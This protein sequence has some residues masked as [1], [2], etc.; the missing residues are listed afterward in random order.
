MEYFPL[1]RSF[2]A[3]NTVQVA[4]DLLGKTLIRIL[5]NRTVLKGM[6]VETEAYQ[7]DDAASHAFRGITPRTQPLFGPVGHA[8]I[9]FIYGNYFCLNIVA[10]DSSIRAGGVLIR[11]LEPIEGMKAML[12]FRH[13]QTIEN[14]TNGP[15]KLTQAFSITKKEQGVDITQQG[16][17][18]VTQ[19]IAL[20]EKEIAI[21]RRV[22]ITKAQQNPWRFYI[23]G[24][25][26]VSKR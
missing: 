24:N 2:Y 1:P 7:S 9:Y 8:Y 14:I 6:I 17:L 4:K 15:G 26:F 3:R 19:G 20:K 22:G 21:S 18:F 11:A 5:P 12:T 10:K 25:A 13:V 23:K 16:S